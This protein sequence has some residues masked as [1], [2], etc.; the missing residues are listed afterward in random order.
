MAFRRGFVSD[1]LNPLQVQAEV[2]RAVQRFPELC[3]LEVLP[4]KTHGYL[5]A[6]TDAHGRQ[7]M[8]ALH[9]TSTRNGDRKPA[10]MLMRSHHAREW[11][12]A[13]VVVEAILQLLENYRA[14]DSDPA[15]QETVRILDSVVL[16]IVPEGNPDGALTS[17]FD[18]GRRMW[19]K[20]LRPNA[21]GC[22]GVDCNRNY[23]EYFGQAGS[24]ADPCT[25]IYHG[26]QP[27]S[28]PE[29]ANIAFL[30]NR[31]K[32]ILFA[33]DSHSSGE[34]IFRPNARGGTFIPTL[35]VSEAD[36]RVYA[37][38]ETE[39]RKRIASVKG[40]QYA[41]GSTSN[42]AGTTDEFLFFAHGVYAFDLECGTDFQP[43]VAEALVSAEEAVQAF[44][45]IAVAATGVTGLDIRQLL[46]NR[47]ARQP[48][49][50]FVEA[51]PDIQ[52]APARPLPEL[53]QV[54]WRSFRVRVHPRS[55]DAL[56]RDALYLQERG[57]DV[58]DHFHDGL[59]IVASVAEIDRLTQLGFGFDTPVPI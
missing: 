51:K 4:H 1:Y 8:A 46:D 39:M 56:V 19:R 54:D 33:I 6:R 26:P 12:N 23:S 10:V 41:V 20:N 34:A 9:I 36:E 30:A 28:E 37:N 21:N 5:G 43:A 13:I 27:L 29:S 7:Q 24:S 15:V 3:R 50:D 47:L 48:R 59:S 49:A 58:D 16:T 2:E 40:T 52:P 53:A 25:E 35:P 55:A 45:A 44:R 18:Q 17:F 32:R 31:E 57:F 42:H 11:I 38:L 14:R 22:F